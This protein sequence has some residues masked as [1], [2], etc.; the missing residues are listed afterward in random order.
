MRPVLLLLLLISTFFNNGYAC[1]N[2]E[3]KELKD[4]T[5]VYEDKPGNVPYGHMFYSDETFQ[6][7]LKRFDSLYKTTKDLDYLSDQ[8]LLLILLKRYQE[9]INLYLELERIKPNRYSTASNLGT[10]YELIGQNENA[11][12]WIQ[13][14]VAINP[15][16][17]NHS[18][19]IHVKIL[20][21]KIKG[22]QFYNT[23]FLLN[24]DF[25]SD[26]LPNSTLK[27]IQ[28][29]KLLNALYYQ[30]N[31]RVSFVKPKEKII[32]QL[33]FDLGNVAFLLG[34]LDDAVTDYELA[35]KYG[36]SGQLIESRIKEASRLHKLPA[37]G[38]KKVVKT[39]VKPDYTTAII[40]VAAAVILLVI[41]NIK[42]QKVKN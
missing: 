8:G 42:K 38:L 15:R 39:R 2:G 27:K 20:E 29:T 11:L 22:E 34:N 33:L 4:G 23:A 28:L 3:I 24:T 7:A 1:L 36:F 37:E 32:A 26:L 21:A 18:E 5:G 10:A 30:L 35:K 13:K 9:A 17:H 12:K 25:G 41:L 16:S 14:A 31:E 40:A 6:K 19:W